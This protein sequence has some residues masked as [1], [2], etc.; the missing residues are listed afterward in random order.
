MC[1][2][3]VALL[4]I[5]FTVYACFLALLSYFA[6]LSISATIF[7]DGQAVS[8]SG[9]RIL[10][11][12]QNRSRI[13]SGEV[14]WMLWTMRKRSLSCPTTAGRIG[15]AR[16]KQRDLCDN[17]LQ[18]DLPYQEKTDPDLRRDA[19]MRMPIIVHLYKVGRS[20]SE[21]ASFLALL[22]RSR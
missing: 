15:E 6:A 4:F 8:P 3:T 14:C 11:R 1:I 10:I 22:Y 19:Q 5:C 9:M 2:K 18:A 12:F 16:A 21:S 20:M 17:T 13:R 7:A